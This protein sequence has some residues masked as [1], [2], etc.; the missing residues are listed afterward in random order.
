MIKDSEKKYVFERISQIAQ[1]KRVAINEKYKCCLTDKE[2][3]DLIY[4][5][6][7]KLRPRC[8]LHLWHG[9]AQAYD[10]EPCRKK[11]API[12]AAYKAANA[13][14]NAKEMEAKDQVMLGSCEEALKLLRELEAFTV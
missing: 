13:R 14:M 9:L 7:V 8:E 1:E 4:A 2:M 3:L 12:L 11:R 6:K 5:K 10:F